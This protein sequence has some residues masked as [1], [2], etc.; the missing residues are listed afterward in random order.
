[1]CL[2]VGDVARCL[3]ST[4]SLLVPIEELFHSSH[5]KM[6][7]QCNSVLLINSGIGITGIV[8]FAYAHWN[9][10]LVKDSASL[11]SDKHI[12]IGSRSDVAQLLAE[13]VAAGLERVD[14]IACSPG[15]LCDNVRAALVKASRKCK[16][17]FELEIEAYSW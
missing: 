3:Q 16:L 4:G 5:N 7:P 1:M 13:E 14:V 11:S 8:P 15:S 12:K 2:P 10:K 17:Q 6:I 9:A